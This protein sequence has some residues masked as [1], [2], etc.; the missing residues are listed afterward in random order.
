MGRILASNCMEFLTGIRNSQI[1]NERMEMEEELMLLLKTYLEILENSIVPGGSVDMTANT[2]G[3][4]ATKLM[5]AL[6]LIQAKAPQDPVHVHFAQGDE[7]T[8]ITVNTKPATLNFGTWIVDTGATNHMCGDASIFH[9]L[10]NLSTPITI[11]LPDNSDLKTKN[12]LAIG[13]QI[14]KLYYLDRNSFISVP[15]SHC[16]NSQTICSSSFTQMYTLW[17]KRLGHP[18]SSVLSHISVLNLNDI[19]KDHICFVCPL[20]K[21]SREPFLVSESHTLVDDY[22]RVSWTFLLHHKAQ[23]A[24]GKPEWENAMKEELTTLEKNNTWDI[25]D[26]PKGKRAIGCSVRT[27]LAVASSLAWPIHQADINN[28]FLHDFL[29]EDIYMLPPDGSSLVA[30]KIIDVKRFLDMEFTIKDLG[31]AKYF[32]GLEIIHSTTD[33]LSAS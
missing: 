2:G 24:K 27:L 33:G 9:S 11:T 21:Q 32:L 23:T 14:G 31:C 7:M 10:H 13:K 19:N 5:E 4:L 3:N 22:S 8:S 12:V 6:K 17:H 28:A 16:N 25:V 1:K 20:A 15:V 30:G 29:D 26:L 18:S